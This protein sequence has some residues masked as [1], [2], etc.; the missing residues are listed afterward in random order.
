MYFSKFSIQIIQLLFILFLGYQLYSG[1]KKGFL[2]R[3]LSLVA[4]ITTM[5]GGWFLAQ[6]LS[7]NIQLFPPQY[8]QEGILQDVIASLLNFW[9]FYILL[10]IIIRILFLFIKPVINKIGMLPLLNQVNQLLGTLFGFIITMIV[11]ILCVVLLKVPL[12]ENGQEVIDHT[13]LRWSNPIVELGFST[14]V[15]QFEDYI[16]LQK[17]L[18]KEAVTEEV[19][20]VIDLLKSFQFT[21]EDI[22]RFLEERGYAK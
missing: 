3:L 12:F 7:K 21:N 4:W 15:D 1:F 20:K 5:V 16:A 11:S 18:A 13:L 6:Y 8:L 10:I 14:V 2:N 17:V 9:V 19:E 22:T